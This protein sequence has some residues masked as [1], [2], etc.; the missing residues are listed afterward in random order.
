MKGRH[1][2]LVDEMLRRGFKHES[3]YE[4]P[5]LSG[6]DLTG[7]VVDRNLSLVEL[8]SRCGECSERAGHG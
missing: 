2:D 8:T 1:D 7:F 5:D 4:Q 6:Y 3:P